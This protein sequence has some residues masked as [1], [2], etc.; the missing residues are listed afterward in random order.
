MLRYKVRFRSP[1]FGC[2]S[3]DESGTLAA[4]LWSEETRQS[5]GPACSQQHTTQ[6]GPAPSQLVPHLIVGHQVQHVEQPRQ[7]LL[8]I[9]VLAGSRGALAPSAAL[10]A[11]NLTTSQKRPPTKACKHARTRLA[12][13]FRRFSLCGHCARTCA[14]PSRSHQR[15]VPGIHASE[16]RQEWP[17]C[18]KMLTQVDWEQQRCGTLS[19]PHRQ[20]ARTACAAILLGSPSR[21]IPEAFEK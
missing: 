6:I 10:L 5:L 17:A 12:N 3:N 1:R 15:N 2:S 20:Q 11:R 13:A 4:A 7:L 8:C 18:P 19:T 16:N 21:T 14:G 9:G